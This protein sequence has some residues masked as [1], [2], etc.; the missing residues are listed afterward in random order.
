[1]KRKKLE[2][3]K[4]EQQTKAQQLV[5][6]SYLTRATQTDYSLEESQKLIKEMLEKD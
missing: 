4:I 3:K 2:D 6:E 1:M 5:L